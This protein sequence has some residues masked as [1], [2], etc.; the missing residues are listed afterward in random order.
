[1]EREEERPVNK[2][3]EVKGGGG[4]IGILVSNQ[5]CLK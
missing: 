4:S 3:K 2:G 1:M 5:R